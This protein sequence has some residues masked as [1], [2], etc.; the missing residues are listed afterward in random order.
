MAKL[1]EN[2]YGDALFELSKEENKV[3]EIFDE[4]VGLIQ[5]LDENPNMVAMMTHPHISKDE[6]LQTVETVFKGKIS[7]EIIGLMRMVIEKDHFGQM[8]DIFEYFVSSV[9]DYKN[10][11]VAY[12]TTPLELSSEKKEEVEKRLLETTK[13]VSLEMHYEID[14]EL[15]GG[16]VIRIGDRVVD[17]SIRTKIYNLSRELSKVQLA[18]SVS[19]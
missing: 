11:G 16:M 1:V 13:F 2:V 7:D 3:D 12:V 6:K 5:I 17:S 18:E 8:K 14:K 4:V 19:E 10:I 15:I 9:K